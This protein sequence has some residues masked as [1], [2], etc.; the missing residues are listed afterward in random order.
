MKKILSVVILITAALSSRSQLVVSHDTTICAGNQV[1]LHASGGNSYSWSPSGT[2]SSTT[3]ANPVASPAQTTSYIVTA[4]YTTPNLVVNSN[5][6]LGDTGFTSGYIYTLPP[7]NSGEGR[8]WVGNNVQ[9]WSSPLTGCGDHT[10]GGGN[11]LMVNGSL[12]A[13]TPIWC[14]TVSLLPNATYNLSAYTVMLTNTNIP[15][16]KW[17]VNGVP[18]GGTNT[19]F[20]TCLWSQLSTTWN[21]GLNTT[22]TFCIYDLNVSSNG[23]DFALDDITITAT[24]TMSDTITV[25]VVNNPVVNLGADTAICGSQSVTLDAG[26]GFA[27][28][29][30]NDNSTAQTVSV[31]SGGS[32]SVTVT[33]NN[34][35]TASDAVVVSQYNLSIS[36]SA[37]NTTCGLNNG[38]ASVTVNNG[39]A[40]YN[41]GWSSGASTANASNLASGTYDVTVN[42]A[43]GCSATGSAVVNASNQGGTVNITSNQTLICASDSAN[44]CAPGGYASYLW[45]TGATTT[46]INTSLAGNYYVTVSDANNCTSTSNHVAVSVYPLPPVS[47]SV[48]GDT[49]KAFNAESYQWYLNGNEISGANTGSY[50]ATVSGNYQVYVTDTNGCGALSTIIPVATGLYDAFSEEWINVYPNPNQTGQWQLNV[51]ESLNGHPFEVTDATGRLVLQSNIIAVNSIIK[52]N[53]S[54]GVY[55]LRITS[56]DKT[57]MKKLIKE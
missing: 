23:N 45:N 26:S 33:D 19:P 9:S 27:A 42:D 28:Y 50:I 36:T 47:I 8:Y 13:N 57:Y 25:T 41:Y 14:N 22:A 32:V 2:L 16:F 24:G 20:L 49:L 11:M 56:G 37:Q 15:S 10:G 31:N 53:V 1:Q 12:V 55:L 35:C 18:T 29:A 52:L 3:S 39:N 54:A 21:S 4:P 40:P 17:T 6:S 5:F 43:A 51:T 30:W 44:I 48:N 46:C 7:N 34:Q 38:S